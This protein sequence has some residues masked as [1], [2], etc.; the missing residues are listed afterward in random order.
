[1]KIADFQEFMNKE[2][3]IAVVGLGYVGLPLSVYLS[4][5]FNVIGFDIKNRRIKE[6]QEGIDRTQEVD[7]ERLKQADL[8]FSDDPESLGS[9]AIII[10]A[11]PTP[12]D[13]AR[14]P[15]MG[16]L[17][18]ATKITAHYLQ[19]NDVIVYESTVYPGAT[20]EIC[21]PILEEY[22]GLTF[23]ISESAVSVRFK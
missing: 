12:I 14:I 1:M 10:I 18:H 5:Y 16:P 4:R 6:L 17:C 11:V 8:T 21:V 20:E 23:G 3:K 2:K 22:S 7:S 15:D 13:D 9:C 19:K